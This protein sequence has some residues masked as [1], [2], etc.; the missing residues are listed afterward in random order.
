MTFAWPRFRMVNA[1]NVEC[2]GIKKLKIYHMENIKIKQLKKQR[3][4]LLIALTDTLEWLQTGKVDG[5]GFDEQ[6]II[7]S[8]KEAITK[9]GKI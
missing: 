1:K 2:A 3:D 8:I 6:S 7:D 4:D 9:Q 5:V